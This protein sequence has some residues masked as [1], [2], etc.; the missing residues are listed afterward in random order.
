MPVATGSV[1]QRLI[2]CGRGDG[3]PADAT[4]STHRCAVPCDKDMPV[5]CGCPWLPGLMLYPKVA[6]CPKAGDYFEVATL[7]EALGGPATTKVEVIDAEPKKST[8]V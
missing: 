1:V 7:T 4:F 3:V 8:V 6:C 2:A 5:A